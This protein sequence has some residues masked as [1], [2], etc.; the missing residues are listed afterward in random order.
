MAGNGGV[1]M[2][3][4]RRSFLSRGTAFAAALGFSGLRAAK[5]VGLAR[6]AAKLRF[7]VVS[8][9]HLSAAGV[10]S[11]GCGDTALLEKAFR[12]F[13]DQ[14]ADAVMIAGDMADRGLIE[15]LELVAQTWNKVFPGNKGLN[16]SMSRSCSST[17]TT[18]ATGSTAIRSA[19]SCQRRCSPP[20]GGSPATQ[21]ASGRASS[22]NP[23][24][25]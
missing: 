16:G 4:N 11:S 13:R 1:N 6:G 7:G 23:G 14:D 24:S 19:T 2:E 9:V 21:V 8:D 20:N 25:R 5:A 3:L 10:K 15:Q 18:T 12:Y 17:A 22:A